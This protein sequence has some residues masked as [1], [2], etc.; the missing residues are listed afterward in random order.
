M[1]NLNDIAV[2]TKVVEASSFTGGSRLLGLPKA[3]VSRKVS[4]LEQR[5][6]VR[7]LERTTR[8]LRLTEAGQHFYARC[9]QHIAA[10][11]QADELINEI[12]TEPQGLLR[13]S[14]PNGGNQLVSTLLAE[15]TAAY[16]KIQ[17]NVIL[18]ETPLDLFEHNIDIAL[19]VGALKDSSLIARKLG[20]TQPWLVAAP[21]YLA[22]KGRP[23]CPADLAGHDFVLLN[24][25]IR[26]HS[27][28]EFQGPQGKESIPVKGRVEGNTLDFVLHSAIAGL[29]IAR[30]PSFAVANHV[31]QGQLQV[32]LSD[33]Q[34]H[35]GDVYVV[36]PS[37]RH[38]ASKV[39]V[40]LEFLDQKMK[41]QP[42][43]IIDPINPS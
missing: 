41:P 28:L 12:Q 13:L 1:L 26:T 2:F 14:M 29:G 38:I 15:F 42:P 33:Y 9:N 32:L 10:L 6:G 7:L 8:K 30:L 17:I 36:Y 19:R 35:M 5:L 24:N 39:R 23:S 31:R 34:L 43:W 3:T 22:R 27:M 16:P 37:R 4:E 25:G 11:E 18:T 21:V 20:P 40:F